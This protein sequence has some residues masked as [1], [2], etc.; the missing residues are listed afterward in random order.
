MFVGRDIIYLLR[1]VVAA[2]SGGGHAPPSFWPVGVTAPTDPLVPE[3]LP[4]PLADQAVWATNMVHILD[5]VCNFIC[6]GYVYKSL[7]FLF[8][9]LF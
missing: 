9:A 4:E 6:P 8:L 2:V 3:P 5:D 7:I 1:R